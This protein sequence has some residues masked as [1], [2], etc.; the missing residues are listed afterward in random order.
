M[1]KRYNDWD[2]TL[3]VIAPLRPASDYVDLLR[4]SPQSRT[5]EFYRIS[6][7]G[8]MT[9]LRRYTGW[10]AT[11]R[12]IVPV[13]YPPSLL[14]YSSI[15]HTAE[16]YSYASS[17]QIQRLWKETGWLS[18]WEQIVSFPYTSNLLPYSSSEHTG[19]V[20]RVSQD[21]SYEVKNHTNFGTNL[22]IVSIRVPFPIIGGILLYAPIT[23]TAFI[24]TVGLN[25]DLTLFK[26]YTNFPYTLKL[27]YRVTHII[28]GPLFSFMIQE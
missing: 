26:Q 28:L 24:K 9:L 5:G 21:G 17:G 25:G 15:D 27:C 20:I 7:T 11:W 1:I 16:L 2:I 13:T 6:D 8:N 3:T 19:R 14:F 23:H 18:S 10:R 12:Q 22:Q 4:Y